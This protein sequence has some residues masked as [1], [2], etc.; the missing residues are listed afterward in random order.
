MNSSRLTNYKYVVGMEENKKK[1]NYCDT[2]Y[3][4]PNLYKRLNIKSIKHGPRV[5]KSKED[6]GK[7]MSQHKHYK[8]NKEL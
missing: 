8:S 6:W 4:I 7:S 3:L 2:T 1:K 5:I